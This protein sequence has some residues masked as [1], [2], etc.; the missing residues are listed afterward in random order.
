LT[1]KNSK[2]Q[3]IKADKYISKPIKFDLNNLKRRFYRADLEFY[4]IDHSG[5]S[6]EGRIFVNNTKATEDTILDLAKGY[7]GSYH[8]FGHG[9]CF[10]NLGHCD[11]NK[12]RLPYDYRPSH[13]LTP[14]YKRITIT[15]YIKAIGNETNEFIITIIPV[16]AGG[17]E[18]T[19]GKIIKLE[20]IRLIIYNK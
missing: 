3:L 1:N 15:N 6:Y 7:V 10:G 19:D 5:P 11:I 12:E 16:I 4:G 20:K 17:N 13:P 18:I 8:I 14:A 2:K 9:G